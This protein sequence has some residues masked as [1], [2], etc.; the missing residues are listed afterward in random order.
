MLCPEGNIVVHVREL[1]CIISAPKRFFLRDFPRTPSQNIL[2]CWG[3]LHGKGLMACAT[4]NVV[5]MARV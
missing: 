4:P 2:K 5:I 1:L 3:H